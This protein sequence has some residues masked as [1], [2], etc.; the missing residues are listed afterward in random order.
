MYRVPTLISH[1]TDNRLRCTS[2][3][4]HFDLWSVEHDSEIA[5]LTA[6][7]AIST[8]RLA[9]AQRQFVSAVIRPAEL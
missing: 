9:T 7:T 8:F 1:S 6:L 2:Q 4:L 5:A 3:G